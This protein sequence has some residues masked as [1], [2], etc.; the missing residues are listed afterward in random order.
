MLHVESRRLKQRLLPITEQAT[1]AIK[2]ALRSLANTKCAEQLLAYKQRMQEL[3]LRPKKLDDFA[4]Y[5]AKA[6][7]RRL[8][9]NSYS[10]ALTRTLMPIISGCGTSPNA[11]RKCIK[12]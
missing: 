4:A 9:G 5:V 11:W 6:N 10:I 2:Q 3:D 12:F 7:V 1:E 8:L